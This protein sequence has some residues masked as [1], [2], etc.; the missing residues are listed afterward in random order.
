MI[1]TSTTCPLAAA[2]LYLEASQLMLP[3]ETWSFR[4]CNAADIYCI[5]V[6][7][8]LQTDQ[9]APGSISWEASRH[10]ASG[11]AHAN[12]I[13]KKRQATQ[14]SHYLFGISNFCSGLLSWIYRIWKNRPVL[15]WHQ[16][17][18]REKKSA[19]T[20]KPEKSLAA[21]GTRSQLL[22]FP[23]QRLAHAKSC[24]VIV[25]FFS[26]RGCSA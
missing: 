14:E 12:R 6:A 17:N 1:D 23:G 7:L 24:K 22:C 19:H 25:K 15:S 5:S 4:R 16:W 13:S 2:H 11:I 10:A 20:A 3:G 9:V 18:E 26:L 21:P 8:H